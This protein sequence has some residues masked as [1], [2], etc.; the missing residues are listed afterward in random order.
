MLLGQEVSQKCVRI[1]RLSINDFA[2]TVV[3]VSDG[4]TKMMGSS[5]QPVASITDRMTNSAHVII[6]FRL[7][8][9][10][11]ASLGI[12]CAFRS[13]TT[14]PPIHRFQSLSNWC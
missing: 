9:N 10:F 13:H 8:L 2:A 11:S 14:C 5:R 6:R 7:C 12:I 3:S 1:I 4:L